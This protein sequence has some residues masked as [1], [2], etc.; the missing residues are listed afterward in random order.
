MKRTV[1]YA[2]D[3]T[4]YSYDVPHY[5]PYGEEITNGT[6]NDTYKF[7]Q[8][9][10][11]SDSGLDYASQ[12]FYASGI[13]RFLTGDSFDASASTSSPQSWNRYAYVQGD[14]VNSY[15][16]S[17]LLLADVG[18]CGTWNDYIEGACDL[19]NWGYWGALIDAVPDI[20]ITYHADPTPSATP[21]SITAQSILGFMD[22]TKAYTAQGQPIAS[23]SEPMATMAYAQDILADAIADN[24][25]PRLL[26]AVSFVEGKWGG[27]ADAAAKDNSF[28]LHN[29]KGKLADFTN[30]GGWAASIQAAADVLKVHIFSDGQTSVS[31]LYGGNHGAY[32]VGPNCSKKS[33]QVGKKLAAQGGNANSLTSPCYQGSDGQYYQKP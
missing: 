6:A 10:R 13:G 2:Y 23:G 14:P 3:T 31:A 8:T 32:C 1:R 29:K 22:S 12:R 7:A 5:Y 28:G 11:D 15:D 24:V 18:T 27:D 17:G 25:D 26:V 4:A 20:H 21:C 16:P 30:A 33:G 19:T 9:Y